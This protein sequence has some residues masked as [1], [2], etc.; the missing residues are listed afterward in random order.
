MTDKSVC[1]VAIQQLETN[2][3]QLVKAEVVRPATDRSAFRLGLTPKLRPYKK[4]R[5]HTVC[6]L[7]DSEKSKEKKLQERE[8]ARAKRR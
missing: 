3:D 5:I 4:A 8:K 7:I 1:R 2:L 6:A